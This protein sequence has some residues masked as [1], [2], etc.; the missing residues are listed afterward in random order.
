MTGWRLVLFCVLL[1]PAWLVGCDKAPALSPG[2][3]PPPFQL[4]DLQ[5][6][7]RRFPEEG[8]Q[9]PLVIRFWADWCPACRN[10]M[11]VLEQQFQ[12]RKARGLRVLAIN[13][14][15]DRATAQ[16]FVEERGLTFDILLDPDSRVAKQYGVVAL[17]TSYLIDKHGKIY[18]KILGETAADLSA[19]LLDSLL[20]TAP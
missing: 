15:Q 18:K 20:E 6:K 7:L 12:Q 10:E 4:E 3:A 19:G 9:P 13:V 1:W 8:T 2:T 5:G 17:P 16:R 14:G 11:T